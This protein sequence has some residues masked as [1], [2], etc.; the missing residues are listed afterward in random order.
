MRSS[1]K[2]SFLRRNSELLPERL[3][4]KADNQTGSTPSRARSILSWA[5]RSSLALYKR[6]EATQLLPKKKDPG[7]PLASNYTPY[8]IGQRPEGIRQTKSRLHSI[9]LLLT[10][11]LLSLCLNG[12]AFALGPKKM[13]KKS[14]GSRGLRFLLTKR[15]SSSTYPGTASSGLRVCPPRRPKGGI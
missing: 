14:G 11:R 13:P 10:W 8:R 3:D 9:L 1:K 12:T 15:S 6:R 4:L 5:F 2:N 7:E